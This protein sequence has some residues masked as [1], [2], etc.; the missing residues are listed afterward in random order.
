MM[1]GF[2]DGRPSQYQRIHELLRAHYSPQQD[3]F[4]FEVSAAH[5][6]A[7]LEGQNPVHYEKWKHYLQ[8][9]KAKMK[10]VLR[11]SPASYTIMHPALEGV[12]TLKREKIGRV[13]YRRTFRVFLSL[14]G[15]FYA[16]F[17]QDEVFIEA[18][19]HLGANNRAV[20]F[21]PVLYPTP[22][23]IYEKWFFLFREAMAEAYPGYEFVPYHTL[24]YRLKDIST[25]IFSAEGRAQTLFQALFSGEDINPYRT[26]IDP[27][28]HP[29]DQSE[30]E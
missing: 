11:V 21:D 3:N 9:V 6:Q 24:T 29:F 28:K 2:S 15:D 16:M 13:V 1:I 26:Q 18:G 27:N 8:S 4:N 10:G 23:D 5:G 7:L 30:F 12:F 25:G 20:A 14:L 22:L 17:G 19:E